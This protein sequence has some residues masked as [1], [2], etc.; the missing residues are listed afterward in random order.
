SDTEIPIDTTPITPG[1]VKRYIEQAL[2]TSKNKPEETDDDKIKLQQMLDSSDS[3]YDEPPEELEIRN[4][5]DKH[6]DNESNKKKMMTKNVDKSNGIYGLSLKNF[7]I[8]LVWIFA[9]MKMS[10]NATS[11]DWSN[12]N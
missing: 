5:P 1:D 6:N 11:V 7:S 8:L 12:D 9:N 2:E 10:G 4:E 3:S